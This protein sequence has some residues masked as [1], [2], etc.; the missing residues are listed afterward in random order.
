M[1][2]P[3]AN[4]GLTLVEVA[5]SML[6]IVL[7]IFAAY[8]SINRGLDANY[9]VAQRVVA[10]GLCRERL[11]QM[12]GAGYDNVTTARFTN[13]ILRLT[14]L[15]GSQRAPLWAQRRSSITNVYLPTRRQ[16]EVV[17]EW[18]FRNRSLSERLVGAIFAKDDTTPPGLT[19]DIG[20]NLRIDP[21]AHPDSDFILS[22]P[23]GAQI[24]HAD[25]IPSFAGFWGPAGSV[26]IRPAGAGTQSSLTLN[27]NPYLVYNR[28]LYDISSDDMT[29]RV[30]NDLVTNGLATGNWWLD[31]T[32][33]AATI[34]T[35]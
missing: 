34:V 28:T 29:V 23:G 19:G 11:E 12:R 13:E 14:H 17:V 7:L 30:W 16:V 27:G 20:G 24:T 6:V 18:S 8:S 21:N 10:F 15:G 2:N 33:T 35:E 31:I 25:L 26:R 32:A 9:E 1:N 22:L 4:R 3:T 5:I